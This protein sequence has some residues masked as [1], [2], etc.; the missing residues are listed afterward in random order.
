[1][2]DER[3]ILPQRRIAWYFGNAALVGN[4]SRPGSS[5]DTDR[6]YGVGFY[7]SSRRRNEGTVAFLSGAHTFEDVDYRIADGH[8]MQTLV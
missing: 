2:A 6:D 8:P 5:L 1:M 3:P 7:D 4:A